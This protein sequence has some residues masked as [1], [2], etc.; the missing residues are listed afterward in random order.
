MKAGLLALVLCASN[1]YA[2]LTQGDILSV[3]SCNSAVD[4]DFF[5]RELT[6]QYG[7]PRQAQGAYWFKV[8][9]QVYS[10]SIKEVF[11]SSDTTVKFVGLLLENSPIEV[12]KAVPVSNTYPTNVF[13]NGNSWVGSDGRVI[14]WHDQKHTKMFCGS[15]KIK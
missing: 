7:K 1:S 14:L 3:V 6:E 5:I 11:V 15:R 9:G 13:A 10:S 4:T 12:T 2:Y 8:S